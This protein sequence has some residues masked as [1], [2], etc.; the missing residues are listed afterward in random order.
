MTDTILMQRLQALQSEIAAADDVT[1][2]S[3]ILQLARVVEAL[4]SEGKAVPQ[5][6]RRLLESHVDDEVE[7]QFDNLPV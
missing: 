3:L 1:R 5:D 7:A 6:A 4:E 2:K